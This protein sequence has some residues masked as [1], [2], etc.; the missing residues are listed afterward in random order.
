MNLIYC[1]NVLDE[2]KESEPVRDERQ[3][4][5]ERARKINEEEQTRSIMN[6]IFYEKKIV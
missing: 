1:A 6:M 4:E 3:K 5:R 2:E